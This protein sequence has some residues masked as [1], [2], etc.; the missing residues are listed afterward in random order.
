MEKEKLLHKDLSYSVR[1]ILY[2]VHNYLGSC[3]NEK[4]YADAIVYGFEKKGISFKREYE[5]PVS[6]EGEMKGR[7]RVDFM[8]ED[9]LILEIKRVPRI[10]RNE[11][12]Q[13][14]RYLASSGKDLCLLVNF[15]PKYLYI[16]RV[17]NPDLVK[18][19][20]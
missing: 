6:F 15:Y 18:K 14:L 16:K 13:C 20:P 5:L 11:L 10:T 2:T 1:G 3:R 7:N 12:H 4:Q 17:L 19:N 8:I 9:T